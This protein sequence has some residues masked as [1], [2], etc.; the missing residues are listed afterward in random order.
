VAPAFAI[1]PDRGLE[2]IG[3]VTAYIPNIAM[4]DTLPGVCSIVSTTPFYKFIKKIKTIEK[5]QKIGA[6]MEV[7][8]ENGGGA[9]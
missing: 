2:V 8:P 5:A 1:V 3:V 4:G 6:E 9:L 7:S